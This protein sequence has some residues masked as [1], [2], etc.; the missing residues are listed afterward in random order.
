MTLH[1]SD[2]LRYAA[3]HEPTTSFSQAVRVL[4]LLLFRNPLLIAL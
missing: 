3:L 2:S 4:R 1:L